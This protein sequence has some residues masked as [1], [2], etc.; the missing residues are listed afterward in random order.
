MWERGIE[1]MDMTAF[2]PTVIMKL[3]VLGIGVT[4]VVLVLCMVFGW[5]AAIVRFW[6][7]PVLSRLLAVCFTILRRIPA[8]AVLVFLHGVLLLSIHSF[9][10]VIPVIRPSLIIALFFLPDFSERLSDRL[11]KA[12]RRRGG[13]GT[14]PLGEQ[15]KESVLALARDISLSVIPEMVCEIWKSSFW[16]IWL[17]GIRNVG[18]INGMLHWLPNCLIIAVIYWIVGLL[19][20]KATQLLAG[21]QRV[22]K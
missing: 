3:L 5:A 8:F 22:R 4:L 1:A 17:F 16:Y 10:D 6:K 21:R 9:Y 12:I 2:E 18:Y 7:T 14:V 19:L 20:G 13:D 11:E 15:G